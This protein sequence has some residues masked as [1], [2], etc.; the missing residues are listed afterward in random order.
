MSEA[1]RLLYTGQRFQ[2]RAVFKVPVFS[3]LSPLIFCFF[4][5]SKDGGQLWEVLPARGSGEETLPIRLGSKSHLSTGPISHSPGS[6]VFCLVL[7]NRTKQT[8]TFSGV[9][10]SELNCVSLKNKSTP[11]VTVLVFHNVIL[12]GN[13]AITDIV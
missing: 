6:R 12:F 13:R 5:S 3:L 4:M 2:S 8:K 11:N 1:R 7:P 9:V 10:C